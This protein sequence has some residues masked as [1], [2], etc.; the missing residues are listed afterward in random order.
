LEAI[1]HAGLKKIYRAAGFKK[2]PVV[3]MILLQ[4]V[5]RWFYGYY[6]YLSRKKAIQHLNTQKRFPFW[7]IWIAALLDFA[8]SFGWLL[9]GLTGFEFS[10]EFSMLYLELAWTILCILF[11]INRIIPVYL[12]GMFLE[13]EGKDTDLT[14][15]IATYLLAFFLGVFYLQYL[16]NQEESGD[17][18]PEEDPLPEEEGR[19]WKKTLKKI[20]GY[21]VMSAMMLFAKCVVTY[22]MILLMPDLS[23]GITVALL[24][25]FLWV[26]FGIASC[27]WA[28]VSLILKKKKTG[29]WILIGLNI[30]DTIV[31]FAGGFFNS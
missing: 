10:Y 27:L 21:N 4:V 29:A 17:E 30:L 26:P 16:I 22:N 1:E 14:N 3:A 24:F 18:V 6:W 9:L 20:N 25:M 19:K 5:T 15:Q 28:I 11:V 31:L 13:H 2:M 12:R 23:S 8:M 7:Y